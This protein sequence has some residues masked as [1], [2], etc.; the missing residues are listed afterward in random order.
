MSI[1]RYDD[2]EQQQDLEDA[3]LP[4]HVTG[5]VTSDEQDLNLI[6]RQVDGKPWRV[7]FYHQ[8]LGTDDPAYP[9]DALNTGVLQPYL[10]VLNM[11]LTVITDLPSVD[12]AMDNT[13]QLEGS[14]IYTFESPPHAGDM[15]TVTLNAGRQALFTVSSVTKRSYNLEPIYVIDYTFVIFTDTTQ[16]ASDLQALEDKVVRILHFDPKT[17]KGKTPTEAKCID[18]LYKI[19]RTIMNRYLEFFIEKESHT[20]LMPGQEYRYFDYYLARFVMDTTSIKEHP[21]LMEVN[22][23]SKLH[24][25]CMDI[26]TIWTALLERNASLLFHCD[27]I[28][29]EVNA[30]SLASVRYHNLV[31]YGWIEKIIYPKHTHPTIPFD[32]HCVEADDLSIVEV[33]PYGRNLTHLPAVGGVP[34]VPLV[35][36]DAFYVFTQNFYDDQTPLTGLEAITLQY[37]KGIDPDGNELLDIAKYYQHWGMLEQYYY[38]PILHYLIQTAI[39][40]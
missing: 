26:A 8:L 30:G 5:C 6:I 39:D 11:E 4:D 18:E 19:K 24:D 20:L 25:R 17:G 23:F 32:N 2:P 13:L 14:S 36:D 10:K 29:G 31:R 1:V 37:L 35:T 16:G 27:A 9:H 38:I 21:K 33:D 15:F 34:H 12:T 22:M 7:T 40:S 28:M 3:S